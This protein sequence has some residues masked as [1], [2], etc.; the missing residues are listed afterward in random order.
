MIAQQ[1]F[2]LIDLPSGARKIGSMW[3]FS[4]KMNEDGSDAR[5]KAR[6]VAKQYTQRP[7]IYFHE[8]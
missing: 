6:L 7:G 8:V 1:V 5:Y 4:Y 3:A 2:E